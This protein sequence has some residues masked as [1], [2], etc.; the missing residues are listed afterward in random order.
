MNKHKLFLVIHFSLFGYSFLFAANIPNFG[1]VTENIYRGARLETEAQYQQL[2]S[3]GI[4]TIINLESLNQDDPK[5]C[6]KYHLKCEKF[7]IPIRPGQGGDR[8]FDYEMLKQAFQSLVNEI[9]SGAKVYIHCHYG[10]DR[11]G[12]LA[13]AITIRKNLCSSENQDKDA[14]WQKVQSD[15]TTYGFH[16]DWYNDLGNTIKSWVYT[17]PSWIC[18]GITKL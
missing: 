14:V 3:S 10:R 9:N 15:L 2:M 7:P 17:S 8:I 5:M 1:Q 13:A 12:S 11:T 4:Q 18:S 16:F 6:T